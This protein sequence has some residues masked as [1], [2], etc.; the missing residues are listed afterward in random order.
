MD[1]MSNFLVRLRALLFVMDIEIHNLTKIR[2]SWNE[3]RLLIGK[4][5][6]DRKIDRYQKLGYYSDELR[7]RRSEFQAKKRLKRRG[8]FIESTSGSLI[9]NPL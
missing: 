6:T 5:L 8:N 7:Q 3:T 4:P 9:Y 2:P 1:A